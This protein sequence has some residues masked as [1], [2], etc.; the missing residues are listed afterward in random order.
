MKRLFALFLAVLMCAAL[1]VPA[2]AESTGTIT[3]KNAAIGKSYTIVKAFTALTSGTA[4]SYEIDEATH[5]NLYKLIVNKVPSPS[6]IKCPFEIVGDAEGTMHT[7]EHAPDPQATEFGRGWLKEMYVEGTAGKIGEVSYDG[8][9]GEGS[10]VTKSCSG[11]ATTVVFDL[12]SM[13]YYMMLVNGASGQE[14]I[15]S[16][17][18]AAPSAVINDK[19]PQSPSD[20]DKT[21]NKTAVQMG[22]VIT[23]EA[24]FLATNYLTITT[25]TRDTRLITEYNL[26][27]EATGLKYDSLVSI[28]GYKTKIE[29]PNPG[30]SQWSG[31]WDGGEGNI[32]YE[33]YHQ[34]ETGGYT[35]R[36]PWVTGDEKNPQPLYPSPIYI[37]ATYT[38]MVDESILAT[39]NEGDNRFAPSFVAGAETIS[40]PNPPDVKVYTTGL[41]LFKTDG[42]N[43]LT[44]AEFILAKVIGQDAQG[45]DILNYYKMGT[46]TTTAGGNS[47]NVIQWV[48]DQADAER[49]E[50]KNKLTEQTFGGLGEG[51]YKLF[52][53]KAPDGFNPPAEPWTI[54]ISFNKETNKFSATITDPTTSETKALAPASSNEWYFTAGILN[55]PTNPLPETGAA[56]TTMLLLVGGAMFAVTMLFLVTK[57]RL[58]NEG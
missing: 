38:M 4:V 33:A 47:Y 48:E 58:Y 10:P 17:V 2:M 21:V 49:R 14:D 18:T 42:N 23:Y 8:W 19:N 50:A 55:K 56:G 20:P 9:K 39:K 26:K 22:D 7:V 27:D 43:N 54:V 12:D 53:T 40:I 37:V 29:N 52:E 3:V 34:T 31:P 6:G 28:K 11:T 45:Q 13:G 46:K 5:P 36:I 24:S 1:A 30:E 35:I 51:T 32:A 16:V 41:S 25:P 44:G 15:A 57:K